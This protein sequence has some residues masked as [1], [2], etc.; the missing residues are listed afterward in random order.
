LA[1]DQIQRA[2][3]SVLVF[4][5]LPSQ[6][7]GEIHTFE[8]AGDGSL[9][10]PCNL[11]DSRVTMLLAVGFTERYQTVALERSNEILLQIELDVH[12]VFARAKPAVIQNPLKF[13]LILHTNPQHGTHQ[14]IL[15]L[16]TFTLFNTCFQITVAHILTD[17]FKG[18][19]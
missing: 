19:W 13:Q 18:Y 2:S 6:P 8:P 14:L 3:T 1:A 15:G 7:N 10:R 11:I 9:F 5:D 17:E 16:K 4:K 12:H